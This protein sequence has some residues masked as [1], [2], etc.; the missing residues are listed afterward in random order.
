MKSSFENTAKELKLNQMTDV[1]KQSPAIALPTPKLHYINQLIQQWLSLPEVQDKLRE[2]VNA[3]KNGTSKYL[4]NRQSADLSDADTSVLD[5]GLRP[6]ELSPRPGDSSPPRSP[7]PFSL[8]KTSRSTR[9][10]TSP[11]H[12]KEHPRPK[13]ICLLQEEQQ[14]TPTTTIPNPKLSSLT[15]SLTK[16]NNINIPSFYF[17]K[18]KPDPMADS[19][20][21]QHITQS[22]L[23]IFKR[24]KDGFI[25]RAEFPEVTRTIGLPVYWKEPLFSLMSAGSDRVS[26]PAF[27][28]M[29]KSL[30][31]NCNDDA[32]RFVYILSGGKK[33]YLVYED[34]EFMLQ[35]VVDSHPGLVFLTSHQEFHSRYIQTVVGRIFFQVNR[36]WSGKITPQEIRR[37]NLLESIKLLELEDDINKLSDYFSYEHFYVIYCKFWELDND[38][39]LVI[40]KAELS[41]YADQTLSPRIIDRIFSNS[42]RSYSSRKQGEDVMTYDDFIRF[43][44]AEED[45]KHPTS[46]EYWFRCMDMDGDGV[47]SLYELEHFYEDQKSRLE[48][49]GAEMPAFLDLACQ[50]LDMVKPRVKNQITLSDIKQCKLGYVFY[51]TFINLDKYLEYEQ[52]DPTARD[53][54]E[55]ISMTDWEKF[56]ALQYES[57]IANESD[58]ETQECVEVESMPD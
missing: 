34:F 36:S 50:M 22:V 43:I 13:K 3:I 7:S 6:R 39:D 51:N 14:T 12:E 25:T 56:A 28:R 37:S 21:R 31:E 32:A 53:P 49:L 24:S 18:G 4:K 10:S 33:G 40:S 20:Y 19:D 2:E 42:V 30:N 23:A 26:F 55:V 16:P 15:H 48:E 17:P 35:D 41:R 58:N 46:I 11:V 1:W 5:N 9:D 52:K 45:K 54:D 8:L 27:K 57:L 29:W 38:H 44:L 47:I